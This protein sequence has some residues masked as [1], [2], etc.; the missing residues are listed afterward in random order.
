M[1]TLASAS[2]RRI[3][4]ASN[5]RGAALITALMV[6][7]LV[8][9]A[10]GALILTTGMSTTTSIDSTAE[11]QAYYG[12]EAGL[13]QAL[14][15]LRGNVAP[16]GG[17]AAGTKLTFKNAVDPTKTN[18]TTDPTTVG[19][20]KRLSAWLQYNYTSTGSAY[21]D[22]VKVNP[23][24]NTYSPLTGIA[25]K[26]EVSDPDGTCGTC[27]DPP[28][29]VIQSIG[30]GPKGS[31]KRLEM[32]VHRNYINFATPGV[33]NLPGGTAINFNMG[34]SNASGYTGNDI[35]NPPVAGIAT[36]A[37]GAA[38]QG[39]AQTVINNLNAQGGGTQVT[40][41]T[42]LALDASNTP[43]FITTADKARAFLTTAADIARG[44]GRYF[45]TQ[46]HVTG[47]L[48][49]S[50]APLTTF[51]D[52]YGGAAVE[53]GA[54]YQ[55]CGLLIVTGPLITQGTTDFQG[56]ILVLGNG[57]FNRD[58]N[59]NGHIDGAIIVANFDP[60]GTGG[61]GTPTFSVN[62]GGNSDVRYDSDAIRKAF[63][64][65]GVFVAGIHEY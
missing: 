2:N 38:N 45:D 41:S 64:S 61:F 39:T 15:A 13:Q 57:T 60:N 34:N 51:I 14:N 27:G 48:G 53:L 7:T 23:T 11:M 58:G 56:V 1:I 30:Y 36:V 12:A 29:L 52:N 19:F 47:G 54:G 20:P 37:V 5:E 28:R 43:D 35:H 6:A 10:G 55:G 42:A 25:F 40:P 44:D 17:V 62:G 9:A 33:I 32:V 4:R 21:P 24:D 22:R 50:S 18:A 26:V 3:T 31:M 49:T 63:D 65:A 59:G 8:L 46:G 16:S